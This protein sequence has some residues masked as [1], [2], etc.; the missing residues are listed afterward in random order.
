VVIP[1]TLV[2]QLASI[3]EKRSDFRAK[4]KRAL[5][6]CESELA[7]TFPESHSHTAK[8]PRIDLHAHGLDAIDEIISTVEKK[9]HPLF[10]VTPVKSKISGVTSALQ[11]VVGEVLRAH[12]TLRSFQA[13]GMWNFEI[14]EVA[15]SPCTEEQGLSSQEPTGEPQTLLFQKLNFQATTKLNELA[16]DDS[17]KALFLLLDW[18]GSYE[19]LFKVSCA[20][21]RMRLH[22]ESEHFKLLLPT[23][24]VFKKGQYLALHQTCNTN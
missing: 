13:K 16:F 22:L 9:Y 3:K 12:V 2:D 14:I 18:L 17:E 20:G 4:G 5:E 23:V 10:R 24:R 8:R 19:D 21:C 11:C 15:I 1:D 7:A 6:S